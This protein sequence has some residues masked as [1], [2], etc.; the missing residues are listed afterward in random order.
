MSQNRHNVRAKTFLIVKV[1]DNEMG[2]IIDISANGV[3]IATNVP[4]KD[5][6]LVSLYID[7]PNYSLEAQGLVT[8]VS[9]E[10]TYGIKF[11]NLSNQDKAMIAQY[12]FRHVLK[13]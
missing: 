11:V 9:A 4:L 7:L 2:T 1:N 6:D 8:R 12:I 10:K 5:G 13:H 3:M